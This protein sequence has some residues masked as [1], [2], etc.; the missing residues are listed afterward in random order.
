MASSNIAKFHKLRDELWCRVRDNCLLGKYSFPDVKV[1]GEPESLGQQ[2]ASELATV[3]YS[4]NAHG[5]YVIESKKDLKTR[6]IDSPNIADALCI[7]EY[8]SN[9]S[10]RVF[11]KD[12]ENYYSEFGKYRDYHSSESAWMGS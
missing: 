8:F 3:R 10:T 11:A 2:L 7:T 1:S 9:D 5:G 12:K 4:F 6:G